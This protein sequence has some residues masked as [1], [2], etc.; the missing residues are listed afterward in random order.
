MRTLDSKV[1]AIVSMFLWKQNVAE[2]F[3]VDVS[4]PMQSYNVSNNYDWLPHNIDP[5]VPTPPEY[6]GVPIQTLGD[7]QQFYE[8]YMQGCRDYWGENEGHH[9]DNTEKDRIEMNIRQ[10]KSMVVSIS[11]NRL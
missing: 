10:P 8:D 9:C 7:K 6:E 2:D 5:D 1:T 11:F 4:F 3:G